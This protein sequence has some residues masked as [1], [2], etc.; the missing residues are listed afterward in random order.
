MWWRLLKE[1]GMGTVVF[2]G[3]W[4]GGHLSSQVRIGWGQGK[5]DKLGPDRGQAPPAQ[6]WVAKESP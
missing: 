3:L 1:G 6:G 2:S 4:G 5:G